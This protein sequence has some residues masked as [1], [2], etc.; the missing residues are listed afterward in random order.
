MPCGN[1]VGILTPILQ[2]EKPRHSTDAQ[3]HTSREQ[4]S[5][6]W[7]REHNT[8]V[9]ITHHQASLPQCR[10][11]PLETQY[12]LWGNCYSLRPPLSETVTPGYQTRRP[13]TSLDFLVHSMGQMTCPDYGQNTCK[14]KVMAQNS[15][16]KM[17]TASCQPTRKLFLAHIMF[18][19]KLGHFL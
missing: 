3:G 4:K 13:N 18:F 11:G 1:P 8:Q 2:T 14:S 9:W 12:H 5:Q 15:S 6:P 10:P 17:V 19:S 16:H 7:P